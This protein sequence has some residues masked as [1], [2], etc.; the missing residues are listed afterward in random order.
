[1]SWP[2]RLRKGTFKLL[3]AVLDLVEPGISDAFPVIV[4]HGIDIISAYTSSR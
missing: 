1:M 4:C 2:F 3:A